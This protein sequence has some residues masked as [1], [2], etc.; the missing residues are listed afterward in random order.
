MEFCN[1]YRLK[2]LEELGQWDEIIQLKPR[3]DPWKTRSLVRSLLLNFDSS[4]DVQELEHIALSSVDPTILTE[5][6]LLYLRNGNKSRASVCISKASDD[7][8]SQFRQLSLL[9]L[10]GH[11]KLLQSVCHITE[12]QSFL[13]NPN[14]NTSTWNSSFP[15]TGDDVVVW[16]SI[17]TLRNYFLQAD[18]SQNQNEVLKSI[19]ILRLQLA[20]VA[21]EQKNA[22]LARKLLEFPIYN[23][24]S[25]PIYQLLKSKII[26]IDVGENKSSTLDRLIQAKEAIKLIDVFDDSVEGSS[27]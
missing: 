5:L 9:N 22:G 20:T 19:S 17:L 15:Q 2:C 10:G 21:L 23:S 14:T 1:E 27:A 11:R 25:L 4:H 16:N 18:N 24:P 26:A 3:K 12:L 13:E 7:L 6:A 8:I